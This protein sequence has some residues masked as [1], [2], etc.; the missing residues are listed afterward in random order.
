[1]A[2]NNNQDITESASSQDKIKKAYDAIDDILQ[3]MCLSE[4]RAIQGICLLLKKENTKYNNAVIS[5]IISVLLRWN[6]IPVK[7][8]EISIKEMTEE[9]KIELD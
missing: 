6:K 4:Q 3:E 2:K 5:N 9:A 8:I 1:M 7:D